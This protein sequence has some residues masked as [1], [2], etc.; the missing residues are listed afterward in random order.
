ME[1]IKCPYCGQEINASS[2]FCPNCGSS[3]EEYKNRVNTD[4]SYDAPLPKDP[5]W[6]NKW[7]TKSTIWKCVFGLA[8]L[9]FGIG[10]IYCLP[11]VIDPDVETLEEGVWGIIFIHATIISFVIFIDAV[12]I[13]RVTTATLDGYNIVIASGLYITLVVEDVII[14]K[15]TNEAGGLFFR[16]YLPKLE[17]IL[18]NKKRFVINYSSSM[19]EPEVRYI[20]ETKDFNL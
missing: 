16:R 13:C 4:S 14:W 8:F 9:M 2:K 12:A 20:D 19:S 6:M 18:P 5:I 10:L 1:K 7:K 11:A 15:K 3:L 17:G